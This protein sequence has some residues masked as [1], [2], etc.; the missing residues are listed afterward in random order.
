MRNR[1]RGHHTPRDF[2]LRTDK[3]SSA[4]LIPTTGASCLD[5]Y[6]DVR[7]AVQLGRELSLDLCSLSDWERRV[8]LSALARLDGRWNCLG[9]DEVHT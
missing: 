4:L 5:R 9:E 3:E 6:R 7:M 1:V 8:Q 2:Y